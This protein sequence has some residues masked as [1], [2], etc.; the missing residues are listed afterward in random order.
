MSESALVTVLAF[1]AVLEAVADLLRLKELSEVTVVV[2]AVLELALVG[3]VA[4]SIVLEGMAVSRLLRATRL[5]GFPRPSS[6]LFPEVLLRGTLARSGL[7][8]SVVVSLGL[9][10]SESLALGLG[11]AVAASSI[12]MEKSAFVGVLAVSSVPEGMASFP[13]RSDFLSFRV[14]KLAFIRCAI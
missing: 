7:C 4:L 3:V 1:I 8:L 2:V 14:H 9:A 6:A 11:L 13:H 10:G 5:S 12:S